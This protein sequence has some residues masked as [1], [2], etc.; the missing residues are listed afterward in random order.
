MPVTLTWYDEPQRILLRQFIGK[1][2]VNEYLADQ[3]AV[4]QIFTS[5]PDRIDVLLD[6]LTADHFL[7]PNVMSHVQQIVQDASYSFPNWGLAVFISKWRMN[8]VLY[9][10]GSR[11]SREYRQHVRLTASY[12][13]ALRLIAADRQAITTRS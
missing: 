11:V 2:T 10:I 13:D 8:Q 9:S 4:R 12:E 7:P 6:L 3:D 1:W 5:T